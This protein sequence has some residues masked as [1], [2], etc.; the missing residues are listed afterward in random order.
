MEFESALSLLL[1]T[2]RYAT[3]ASSSSVVA[4]LAGAYVASLLASARRPQFSDHIW[5]GLTWA[6]IPGIIGARALVCPLPAN[7]ADQ[8]A[9]ALKAKPLPGH[10]LVSSTISSIPRKRRHRYLERRA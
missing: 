7:L 2:C 8:K 1:A 4:L 6:I 9:A 5:G 3:T 10:R